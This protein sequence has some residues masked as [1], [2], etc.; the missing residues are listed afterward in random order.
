MS[1]I[2]AIFGTEPGADARMR[3]V[4]AAM[5]EWPHDAHESWIASEAGLSA[6]VQHTTAESIEAS[7]PHVNDDGTVRLVLDGYL[8]N[9]DDLRQELAGRGA[10]LRNRSD[11]E[12]V[13]RAYEMWG[14][15][16]VDH[17]EGEFAFIMIDQRER[18][19]FCARDHA[20]LRPLYYA[21]CGGFL[22][23]ASNLP[24]LLAGLDR[25]P[26]PDLE[27]LAETMIGET[28]SVDRTVWKDVHRLKAAHC[29]S[30]AEGRCQTRSYYRLP[31]VSFRR[32]GL[33]P[34]P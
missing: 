8:A 21:E 30:W 25:E 14:E 3:R 13:L 33:P 17:I 9:Y 18:R 32:F 26:R 29:L 23:V 22:I 15:D 11:A 4:V 28:Y 34:Y 1:E 27:Y 12:L 24:V 31:P 10:R 7:Q 6:C 5:G 16:C 20:G 19:A 2:A